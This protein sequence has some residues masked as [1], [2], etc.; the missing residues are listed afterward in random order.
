MFVYETVAKSGNIFID[1]EALAKQGDN[2]IGTVRPSVRPF[3][4][5]S[6]G[7]FVRALLFKPFDL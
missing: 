5:L 2:R 3:V 6:V 1:R 4:G 7:M